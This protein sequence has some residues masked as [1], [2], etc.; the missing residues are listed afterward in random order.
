MISKSLGPMVMPRWVGFALQGLLQGSM[1]FSFLAVAGLGSAQAT[2]IVDVRMGAH[3][4]Y[5]RLVFETDSPAAYRVERGE[6]GE[7]VLVSIQARSGALV[8]RSPA[9]PISSV[10]VAP[11]GAGSQARVEVF[12]S[13]ARIKEMVLRSP[14]RIVLD[15]MDPE[16]GAEPAEVAIA[17]P[18]PQAIAAEEAPA[19]D[20]ITET[21]VSA[22][23]TEPVVDIWSVDIWALEP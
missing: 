10:T 19:P 1:L 16:P 5:V 14:P 4:G 3:K 2:E 12:R 9:A 21:S 8:M 7:E 20:P 22:P 18:A 17:T 15:F 13:G 6:G 23:P 11:L